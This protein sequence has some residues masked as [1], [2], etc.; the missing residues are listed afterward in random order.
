M[1]PARIAE[2]SEAFE[3]LEGHSI[4]LSDAV[5]MALTLHKERNSSIPFLGL[6]D[7]Y[8]VRI[9]NRSA[10]HRNAMRQTRD[11]FPSLHTVLT[12]DI[13]PKALDDLL[14]PMPRASR[15]LVMRHWRSVFRYGIKR[16]Y[17]NSNPIE[18]LDFA[19]TQAKEVEIY[20]VT[21][22]EA[23]LNDALT[24]DLAL[25]PFYAF[26]FLCGIRPEGELEALDWRYVHAKARKPHVS[27]PATVSK[28]RKFREV[29]LPPSAVA[30]ICEYQ[31]RGG[32]MEGK[33]VPWQHETLRNHRKASAERV[34]LVWIQ[35]GM[36]HSFASYWLP[37]HHDIDMLLNQMGHTDP[38]TFSRHYHAG[39]PLSE[40]KKFW[41]IRPKRL[42]A[43]NIIAFKQAV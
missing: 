9:Q 33:I 12:C 7:L 4:S 20:E 10:K 17:L 37:V 30:W 22:V 5:G 11:R 41:A 6:F 2:A 8:L 26:G 28:V 38:A 13:T 19:G 40:A 14:L 3:L 34:G 25:L 39:V 31:N 29:D 21:S 23:L 35:D 24:N 15:D 1:T 16:Q 27:I 42:K 18:R 32:A 36:R 43:N